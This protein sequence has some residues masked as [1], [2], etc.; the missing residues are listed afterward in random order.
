MQIYPLSGEDNVQKKAYNF[1]IGIILTLLIS[2]FSLSIPLEAQTPFFPHISVQPSSQEVPLGETFQIQ[3]YVDAME[4]RIRG[5]AIDLS[6]TPTILQVKNITL[7]PL[8]GSSILVKPGSGDD[9]AGNI[10]YTVVTTQSLSS[11]QGVFLTINFLVIGGTPGSLHLLRL[12]GELYSWSYDKIPDVE[13]NLGFF[14]IGE[15]DYDEYF[16]SVI[17]SGFDSNYDGYNDAV[18]VLMDA[19]T[20]GESTKISVQGTLLDP[21][22]G[23]DDDAQISWT[24][25][26]ATPEARSL[27]LYGDGPEGWFTVTLDLF[28]KRNQH[29]DSWT[30]TIYLYPL[31]LPVTYTYINATLLPQ[32]VQAG[33]S[34][35]LSVAITPGRPL[36]GIHLGISFNPSFLTIKD[37]QEGDLFQGIT[38]SFNKGTTDNPNGTLA[39]IYATTLNDTVADPGIFLIVN[40]AAKYFPG[41][42]T[43]SIIDA[44]ADDPAG[45]SVPL[46]ITNGTLIIEKGTLYDLTGDGRVN[47]LDLV[48]LARRW[49]ETGTPGWM[50]E[51]LNWDGTINI[52]DIIILANNWTQ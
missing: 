14:T 7:G 37:V 48:I 4:Y 30:G 11:S 18:H 9:G 36:A 23:T 25:P 38:H 3:I 24:T 26:G 12:A 8:L 39:Q 47:I 22:G 52:Q 51:D 16:L 17:L 40:M 10:H 19:G 2:S 42:A 29:E 49:G 5:V 1:T 6:Y 31:T 46:V 34:F 44:R 43:L 27:Y 45:K 20:M 13:I 33:D 15:P 41:M 35:S 28:D 21:E 50:P 32:I